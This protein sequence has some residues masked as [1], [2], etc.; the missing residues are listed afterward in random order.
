MITYDNVRYA[1]RAGS[2]ITIQ[3]VIRTV[4]PIE[5]RGGRPMRRLDITDGH[6]GA[7]LV[8]FGDAAHTSYRKGGT[9]RAGPVYWS[10]QYGNFAL[11]RGGVVHVI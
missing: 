4:G 10:E 1:R 6:E 11:T 9:I 2:D 3:C 7:S 5:S 8:L